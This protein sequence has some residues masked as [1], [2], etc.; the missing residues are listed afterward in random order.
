MWVSLSASARLDNFHSKKEAFKDY[1]VHGHLFVIEEQSVLEEIMEKLEESEKSGKLKEMQAGFV[2][3]VKKRVLR[4]MRVANIG[5]AKSNR[6]WTYNPSYTQKTTLTDHKGR[7]I[8]AAGTTVNALD[9]LQWGEAFIFI[10]GD[11]REQV[12]FAKGRKGR[13]ILV[14][15][16][17]IKLSE[18]LGRRVYFDQ[19]GIYCN[20][21]KIE[22]VPAIVEQEG[23]RLKISEVSL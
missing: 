13:I 17:P 14:G 6:S 15:G 8:V 10:D 20:K 18:E 22:S 21:F 1:G 11:D 5:R 16:M 7:V 23:R 9:K 12:E 3:R 2:E 4:P 19:G